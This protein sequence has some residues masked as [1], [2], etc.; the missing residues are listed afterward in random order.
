MQKYFENELI[1]SA[2]GELGRGH[3]RKRVIKSVIDLV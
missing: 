3:G 2:C 1:T